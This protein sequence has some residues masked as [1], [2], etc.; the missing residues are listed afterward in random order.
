MA[1]AGC[2]TSQPG[3]HHSITTRLVNIV[4]EPS[5]TRCTLSQL[6]YQRTAPT[7]SIVLEAP[8]DADH[9]T[10]SCHPAAPLVAAHPS[11]LLENTRLVLPSHLLNIALSDNS[12]V[13]QDDPEFLLVDGLSEGI[14]CGQHRAAVKLSEIQRLNCLAV[15]IAELCVLRTFGGVD[16]SLVFICAQPVSEF[17]WNRLHASIEFPVMPKRAQYARF[18]G[19]YP[20]AIFRSSILSQAP[21][22]IS[23]QSW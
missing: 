7:H 18:S 12:T 11:P 9:P 1:A 5:P 2:Q 6:Q 3:A 21:V 16:F 20:C 10:L 13:Y 17:V 19:E 23:F 14:C 22:D 15:F 8:Q 4:W